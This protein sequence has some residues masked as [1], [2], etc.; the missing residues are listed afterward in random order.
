MLRETPVPGAAPEGWRGASSRSVPT[1]ATVDLAH[2]GVEA[3]VDLRRRDDARAAA[4]ELQRAQDSMTSTHLL[5][6]LTNGLLAGLER[7]PAIDPLHRDAVARQRAFPGSV[8]LFRA[9][10]DASR[11]VPQR[12]AETC[13][14]R[15]HG[16]FH[17]GITRM[18]AALGQVSTFRPV[19][20]AGWRVRAWMFLVFMAIMPGNLSAGTDRPRAVTRCR[21]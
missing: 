4:E 7:I 18:G 16:A 19:P 20:V 13:G 3:E 12:F 2:L 8:R 1:L 10:P 21:G 5:I 6:M 15:A 9:A 11:S 17:K 14:A